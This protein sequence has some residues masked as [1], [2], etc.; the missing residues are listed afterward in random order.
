[1]GN[2]SNGYVLERFSANDTV[3]VTRAIID[4]EENPKLEQYIVCLALV[5]D[6]PLDCALRKK[7][8]DLV[9]PTKFKDER[10]WIHAVVVDSIS[11]NIR[12]S[13]ATNVSNFTSVL[14]EQG[15]LFQTN[16]GVIVNVPESLKDYDFR[17]H[18]S[19]Y[20]TNETFVNMQVN[21]TILSKMINELSNSI[22]DYQN[23]TA[24]RSGFRDSVEQW[25]KICK[26]FQEWFDEDVWTRCITLYENATN[27]KNFSSISSGDKDTVTINAEWKEDL[28]V[29]N[30]LI[31]TSL[32]VFSAGTVTGLLQFLYNNNNKQNVQ[33]EMSQPDLTFNIVCH[34]DKVLYV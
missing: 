1:M 25:F 20:V 31:S 12:K 22:R 24:W 3:D 27:G 23:A 15:K 4:Y 7:V 32:N 14:D 13:H 21:S 2:I 34:N 10:K 26:L 33:E 19:K 18:I 17:N 9:I 16:E 11:Q 5:A 29:K 8:Q 6:S 30:S 28:K